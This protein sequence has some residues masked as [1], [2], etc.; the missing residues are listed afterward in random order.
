[1]HVEIIALISQLCMGIHCLSKPSDIGQKRI[2]SN[3]RKLQ[4]KGID[5]Y[6]IISK[7]VFTYE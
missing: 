2:L 7:N 6:E 1:M 3:L 4:Q 5:T